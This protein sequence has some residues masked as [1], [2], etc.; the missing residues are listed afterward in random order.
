MQR[1]ITN[2]QAKEFMEKI[3]HN[4]TEILELIHKED[5]KNHLIKKRYLHYYSTT[6]RDILNEAD[7]NFDYY[8]LLKYFNK[9]F[10]PQFIK[11]GFYI[12]IEDS[13]K[14]K[15]VNDKLDNLIKEIT[16]MLDEIY[17]IN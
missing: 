15:S 7:H 1:N 13:Y 3:L 12:H 17:S 8:D 14:Y 9:I 4:L 10:P 6:I 2:I 16:D 11:A 5:P